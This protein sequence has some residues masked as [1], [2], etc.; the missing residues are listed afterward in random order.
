MYVGRTIRPLPARVRSHRSARNAVWL[1]SCNQ[2]LAAWLRSNVPV[3]VPLEEV[4]ADGNE[5]EREKAWIHQLAS[6]VLLNI[7]GNP[8]R[9]PPRRRGGRRPPGAAAA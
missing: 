1:K 4:P 8:L 6:P 2:E 7:R 5:W 3:A 9:Q